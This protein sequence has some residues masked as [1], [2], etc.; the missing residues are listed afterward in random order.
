MQGIHYYPIITSD[1]LTSKDSASKTMGTFPD[2]GV[3]LDMF[4]PRRL[5]FLI[6]ACLILESPESF[7]VFHFSLVFLSLVPSAQ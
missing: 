6:T 3:Q 1:W 4:D 5:T 2:L 7:V